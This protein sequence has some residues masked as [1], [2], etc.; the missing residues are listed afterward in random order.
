MGSTFSSFPPHT[1]QVG[2]NLASRLLTAAWGWVT[3]IFTLSKV[4]PKLLN[5]FGL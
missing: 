3:G 4:S 5:R 2:S 1:H